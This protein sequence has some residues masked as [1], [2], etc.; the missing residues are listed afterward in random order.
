M[1]FGPA[2]DRNCGSGAWR[3]G[4]VFAAG[5]IEIIRRAGLLR[6]YFP[7]AFDRVSEARTK[8]TDL[9]VAG[10]ADAMGDTE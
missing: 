9:A 3:S 4:R 5:A 10:L 1:R 2:S 6:S 7:A 8:A